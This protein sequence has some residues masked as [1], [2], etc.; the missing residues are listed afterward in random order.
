MDEK[1]T[2][3]LT[4]AAK[5]ENIFFKND[6]TTPSYAKIHVILSKCDNVIENIQIHMS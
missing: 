3:I 1:F 4:F 6:Y 5:Y 2:W